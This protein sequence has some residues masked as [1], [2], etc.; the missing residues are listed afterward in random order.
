MK[1]NPRTTA[2]WMQICKLPL[3]K[4]ATLNQLKRSSANLL[5]LV[6]CL[7]SSLPLPFSWSQTDVNAP[8]KQQCAMISSLIWVCVCLRIGL[9]NNSNFERHHHTKTIV[10]NWLLLAPKSSWAKSLDFVQCVNGPL[11]FNWYTKSHP[12]S[13]AILPPSYTLWLVVRVRTFVIHLHR[14]AN[15]S[16][17]IT[18]KRKMST[19]PKRREKR[20]VPG[21]MWIKAFDQS[22]KLNQQ[23]AK[24]SLN[25]ADKDNRCLCLIEILMVA[26]WMRSL[27]RLSISCSQAHVIT[28]VASAAIIAERSWILFLERHC[29]SSDASSSHDAIASLSL[30]I[31]IYPLVRF[32]RFIWQPKADTWATE[33]KKLSSNWKPQTGGWM[34]KATRISMTK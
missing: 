23:D 2:K 25:Q 14:N 8:N 24:R 28:Q 13:A 20:W 18:F 34:G 31:W 16:P 29:F 4:K 15:K 30:S 33:Q 9:D 6:C 7:S 11:P 17:R 10:S 1:L 12:N 27:V 21:E 32:A 3:S 19:A 5:L 22:L 26:G